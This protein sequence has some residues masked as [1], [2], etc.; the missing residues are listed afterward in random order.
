MDVVCWYMQLIIW[1]YAEWRPVHWS[2]TLILV[3]LFVCLFLNERLTY[4][5]GA[6]AF[7]PLS[8]KWQKFCLLM[9]FWRLRCYLIMQHYS[10]R[11]WT[12]S[13]VC[14]V[15]FC[16]FVLFFERGDPRYLCI[17]RNDSRSVQLLM[18]L[19]GIILII[20][21]SFEDAFKSSMVHLQKR[22]LNLNLFSIS[23]FGSEWIISGAC[24]F[25]LLCIRW[26]TKL[27]GGVTF[28]HQQCGKLDVECIKSRHSQDCSYNLRI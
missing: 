12:A 9:L 28:Y 17:S 4:M 20:L 22:K 13:F 16:L 2:K 5:Y 14:F 15:L 25:S 11:T 3:C 10:C 21:M 27:V 6:C 8:C 7:W 24:V 23:L 18:L 1:M 26:H 19:S